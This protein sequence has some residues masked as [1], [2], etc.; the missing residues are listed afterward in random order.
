MV[1]IVKYTTV[2]TS[3]TSGV[4]RVN[5]VRQELV[6]RGKKKKETSN[7]EIVSKCPSEVNKKKRLDIYVINQ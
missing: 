7:S 5:M 6:S 3:A 4:H 1:F 2:A